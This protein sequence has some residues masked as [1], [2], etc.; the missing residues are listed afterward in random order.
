MKYVLGFSV[1]FSLTMTWAAAPPQCYWWA[2]LSV[3]VL[4]NGLVV[5]ANAWKMP[6][7]GRCE[8]GPRHQ[9]M[10][11]DT[12][13]KWL[14]D[15][16]PTGLGRASFGDFAICAGIL[17]VAANRG[18]VTLAMALVVAWLLPWISG[19]SGGFRLF[20]KW[21]REERRDARKNIP[22]V[23]TL[24]I[25]G[26]LLGIRG[27]SAPELRACARSAAAA[28]MPENEIAPPK[29]R[30]LTKLAT[31]TAPPV[32][33]FEV[34]RRLR[35]EQSVRDRQAVMDA[36]TQAKQP[37]TLLIAASNDGSRW[38]LTG[39][40]V[41][42]RNKGRACR[43]TCLV[44]HNN[45]YD[46]ETDE[47]LCRANWIPPQS[48]IVPGWYVYAFD[49]DHEVRNPWPGPATKGFISYKLYWK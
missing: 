11:R 10:T 33:P 26:N 13:L 35:R 1:L 37:A 14:A 46:V 24:V 44:H 49:Q 16:V 23:L 28:V 7:M 17:G 6:V 8:E 31:Q 12:R 43:I 32:T 25:I 39:T 27:C 3:G 2:V 36:V 40:G 45:T 9:P 19:C 15:I 18:Q 5:G 47:S 4:L 41:R 30:L 48:D 22:I 29:T 20:E 42:L 38:A 21:T 34:L